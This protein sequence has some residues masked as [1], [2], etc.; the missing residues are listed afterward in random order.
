[1]TDIGN[2]QKQST[3]LFGTT[4]TVSFWITPAICAQDSLRK[5]FSFLRWRLIFIVFL[6]KLANKRK[7]CYIVLI[8]EFIR[9]VS[10]GMRDTFCFTYTV[11]HCRL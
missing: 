6:I 7:I 11:L 1:M 8:N 3:L 2:G 4:S 5:I 9:R 10:W